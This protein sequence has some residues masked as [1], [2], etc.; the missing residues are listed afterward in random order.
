MEAAMHG[1]EVGDGQPGL[2]LRG[3]DRGMPEHFLQMPDRS[4]GPA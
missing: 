4:A 3:L 1:L 2:D